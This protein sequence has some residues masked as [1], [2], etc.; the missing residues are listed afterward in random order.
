MSGTV[1]FIGIGAARSGTTWIAEVLRAHAEI[2]I[3]EP[4]EVRYFNR[5]VLPFTWDKAINRPAKLRLKAV[6]RVGFSM[7][8]ALV[9]ARLGWAVAALRKFGAHG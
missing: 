2:C 1:D 9:D 7:A 5:H 4:K 6:K 8:Q 3:S